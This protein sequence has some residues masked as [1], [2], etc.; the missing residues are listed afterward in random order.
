MRDNLL[1]S[2]ISETDN[3]RQEYSVKEFMT[4]KMKL[5]PDLVEK[6]TF[7]RVHRMG[8][9]FRGRPRTIIVR[10]EHSKTE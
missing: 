4:K 3:I 6:I 9:S 2:G 1:F 5:L 7:F 8:K 10:F